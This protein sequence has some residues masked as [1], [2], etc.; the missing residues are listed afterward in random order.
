MAKS[1]SMAGVRDCDRS[2]PAGRAQYGPRGLC[3]G[4]WDT[5]TRSVGAIHRQL[6]SEL[7][8]KLI[9]IYQRYDNILV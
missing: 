5:Q 1:M 4:A 2:S 3:T 8:D 7:K 6:I 9:T